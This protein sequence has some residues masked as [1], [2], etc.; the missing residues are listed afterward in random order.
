MFFHAPLAQTVYIDKSY[1]CEPRVN[2]IFDAGIKPDH[3]RTLES[4]QSFGAFFRS[5]TS[6]IVR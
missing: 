1:F 3:E 5:I 2:R 6:S 4:Y